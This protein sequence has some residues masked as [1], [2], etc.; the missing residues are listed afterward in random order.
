MGR[1]KALLTI[2]GVAMAVRVAHALT[3]AGACAV[4]CIGGDVSALTA[5]GLDAAG[6]DHPHVGPLG[7][8]LTALARSGSRPVLVAPCDL[9]APEA[10]SFRRLIDALRSSDADAAVP[11]V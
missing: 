9:A 4:C 5:L 2:D 10:S 1:D 6:G 8:V 3:A 11:V 7:G